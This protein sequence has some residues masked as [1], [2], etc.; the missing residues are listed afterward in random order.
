M[1][2]YMGMF[3]T[4]RINTSYTH[5]QIGVKT[6]ERKMSIYTFS[7]TIED[8]ESALP[9]LPEGILKDNFQFGINHMKWL[10]SRDR[11]QDIGQ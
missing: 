3:I 8:M 1:M 11:I 4:D 5:L 6:M 9:Y 2:M 10:L 7:N